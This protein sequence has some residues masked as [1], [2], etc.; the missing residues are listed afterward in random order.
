MWE[1]GTAARC[2]SL[3]Q[4]KATAPVEDKGIP[5]RAAPDTSTPWH[6]TDCCP[7][8]SVQRCFLHFEMRMSARRK[9]VENT[10]QRSMRY[11][12]VEE[13]SVLQLSSRQTSN[14]LSCTSAHSETLLSTVARLQSSLRCCQRRCPR[15]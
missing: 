7:A 14:F 15:V 11:Q 2:G 9:Y 5:Q 4:R 12:A 1:G 10:Q 13:L 8:S 3:A 6:C